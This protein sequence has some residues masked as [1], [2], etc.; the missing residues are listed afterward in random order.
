M[1]EIIVICLAIPVIF[2][3]WF[4]YSSINNR[5]PN[6]EIDQAMREGRK[7]SY[8]KTTRGRKIGGRI[9]LTALYLWIFGAA[10]GFFYMDINVSF[11]GDFFIIAGLEIAGVIVI[12]IIS[13]LIGF[14]IYCSPKDFKYASRVDIGRARGQ[15]LRARY[16][17]KSDDTPFFLS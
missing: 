5:R 6:D 17:Q 12:L 16:S 1:I 3:I 10:I 13:K 7:V 8:W 2:G 14:D 4:S 9:T 11:W 15:A